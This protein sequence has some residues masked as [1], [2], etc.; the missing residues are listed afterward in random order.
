[1]I[2]LRVAVCVSLTLAAA[3]ALA[4]RAPNSVVKLE[5]GADHV[6]AEVMVPR[7]ELAYALPS[8]QV[9]AELPAYLLRHIA[10]ETP[11]GRPWN[12]RILALREANYLEHDYV[13]AEIDLVPPRGAAVSSFVLVNDAVTH[14]VRN[15]I[16]WV[17]DTGSNALLGSLQ[18]P[19]R[20]LIVNPPTR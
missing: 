9:A 17:V 11:E 2:R 10:A 16:V 14:E 6:R 3:A 18:Y 5:F 4:H 12:V 7:T 8:A 20:R 15:H 1:M 19:A 13:L